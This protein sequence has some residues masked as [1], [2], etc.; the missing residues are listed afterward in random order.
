MA[1]L[2]MEG[3]DGQADPAD[4]GDVTTG[5]N[6]DV[7]NGTNGRESS[8]ALNISYRRPDGHARGL[9][10]P[11]DGSTDDLWAGLW[12]K[13]QNVAGGAEYI[14][15]LL[16]LYIGETPVL[17]LNYYATT[18][19]DRGAMLDVNPDMN[20]LPPEIPDH[21]GDTGLGNSGTGVHLLMHVERGESAGIVRV[22]VDGTLGLVATGITELA[23]SAGAISSVLWTARSRWTDNNSSRAYL[24]DLWVGTQNYGDARIVLMVPDADG[25]HQDGTPSTGSDRFALL[26]DVP[27]NDSTHVTLAADEQMSFVMDDSALAALSALRLGAIQIE[28]RFSGPA[29][30]TAFAR[31][32]G[33]DYDLDSYNNSTGDVGTGR[34]ISDDNPAA[35]ALWGGSF[36]GIELGVRT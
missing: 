17:S 31:I 29:T 33:T 21:I 1:V 5:T 8:R 12:A 15:R 6:I 36:T 16:V 10:V 27:P 14:T 4:I 2:F 24:D 3:W 20:A 9:L 26:D 28:P 30:V 7:T 22:W 18:G 34:I 35:V 19:A 25:F 23:Q 13:W 11:V 32:A